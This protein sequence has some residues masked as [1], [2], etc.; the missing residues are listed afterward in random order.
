[1]RL[2]EQVFAGVS[3]LRNGVSMRSTNDTC[4]GVRLKIYQTV[5]CSVHVGVGLAYL[6]CM[7]GVV[8]MTR[9]HCSHVS[10]IRV[11]NASVTCMNAC[12]N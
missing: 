12:V 9:T 4:L 11:H 6:R 7:F 10:K 5:K 3:V 8:Y 1:M 2:G